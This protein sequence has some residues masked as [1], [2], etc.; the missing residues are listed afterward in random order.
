M[1]YYGYCIEGWFRLI[2]PLIPVT[3]FGDLQID[4]LS[5]LIISIEWR[6]IKTYVSRDCRCGRFI[7]DEIVAMKPHWKTLSNIN[8]SF[9]PPSPALFHWMQKQQQWWPNCQNVCS[10]HPKDTTHN[11]SGLYCLCYQYMDL[12]KWDLDPILSSRKKTK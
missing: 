1:Q 3:S 9:H 5:H 8:S 12:Y 10:S 7:C 6:S 4:R 11:A 2:I